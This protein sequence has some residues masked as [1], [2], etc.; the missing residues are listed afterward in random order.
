MPH[1]QNSGGSSGAPN[2]GRDRD[3]HSDFAPGVVGVG[4]LLASSLSPLRHHEIAIAAEDH[5]TDRQA[6][7]DVGTG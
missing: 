7:H 1:G 5:D 6:A 4:A 3:D 2:R